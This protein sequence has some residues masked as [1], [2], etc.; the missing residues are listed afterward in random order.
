MQETS[1]ITFGRFRLDSTNECLWQGTQAIPLRPKAFAVLKLLIEHAGQLVT[2]QQLLERVWP[3]TYVSDAVL[4]ASIRQLREAMGDAADAPQY[5]ETAHRR[6]YRFIGHTAGGR[7][8]EAVEQDLPARDPLASNPARSAAPAPPAAPS[9]VL[10]RDRELG[11][12]REWLERALAGERQVV[13]VTGEPGIGKTTLVNALL[14]EVS[15]ATNMRVA[16]GQCLEQYG[17]GE[18]YLPVLEGLS[19][20]GRAEGGERIIELLRQHA[21]AWLLELPSLLGAG[22]REMLRQQAA[23]ADA[24]EDAA[25]DGRGHRG[26]RHGSAADPRPRRSPLERLL[27][28]RPRGV[29]GATPRP[30]AADGH[31]HVSTGRVILGD[32]PLKAVKR[33]LHA[34]ALS[35]ELPL[36]YL[37][38]EA[39][40]QYLEVRFPRHQL[41]KRLARLV[42]RRSEGNPL[43]MVNLAEYLVDEQIIA[44]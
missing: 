42:H 39:V 33:E 24:R 2:K 3:A 31:W 30:R 18:A 6:G 36:D 5:I 32:H 37:T 27:H 41:P 44:L 16:R 1:Q 22:R 26:D 38:E 17:A 19:R 14:Q 11:R 7:D 28:A 23:G 20:L 25:R 10:G 40:A 29:S 13:F 43:F 34:H 8:A 9:N 12:L 21:P 4:K 15:A 35:R